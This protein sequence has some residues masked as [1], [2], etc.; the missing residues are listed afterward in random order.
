[1]QE[2]AS[3]SPRRQVSAP[4]PQTREENGEDAAWRSRN[5]GASPQAQRRPEEEEGFWPF[6]DGEIIECRKIA[7]RDFAAFQKRDWGL[8]NNRF[9]LFG[10]QQFGYLLL[11]R[12]RNGQYILGVP[13]FYDQQERFMAGMFGFPYFK[14]SRLPEFEGRHGGFWYRLIHTPNFHPVNRSQ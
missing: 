12:L 14:T 3:E 8:H 2:P 11:G 4:I 9:L 13:G 5:E 10:Y 1:M 6:P 7:P